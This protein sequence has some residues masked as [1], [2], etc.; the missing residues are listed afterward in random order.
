[1]FGAKPTEAKRSEAKRS[2]ADRT[3]PNRTE[4]NRTDRTE[5]RISVEEFA[6]GTAGLQGST[7][8]EWPQLRSQKLPRRP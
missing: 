5:T 4:P 2:G 8:L 6:L 7:A 3:G 1:M